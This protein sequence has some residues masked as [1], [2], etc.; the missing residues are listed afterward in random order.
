MQ[1]SS[2]NPNEVGG[3]GEQGLMQIT[4]VSQDQ[5]PAVAVADHPQGQVRSCSRWRLQ[6]TRSCFFLCFSP[7]A[8]LPAAVVQH[9]DRRIV[10]RW[11]D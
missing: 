4:K 1:E 5:W 7:R 2:C 9:H 3:A 11:L 6:D 10:L 8:N